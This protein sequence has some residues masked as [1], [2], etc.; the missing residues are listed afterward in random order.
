MGGIISFPP[1]V[2]IRDFDQNQT[3]QYQHMLPAFFSPYLTSTDLIICQKHWETITLDT[4]SGYQQNAS[5]KA[6]YDS[7]K[8]WLHTLLYHELMITST[9]STK[10]P[11]SRHTFIS[12]MKAIVVIALKQQKDNYES[13]DME[14]KLLTS[15]IQSLGYQ[16]FDIF[17]SFSYTFLNSLKVISGREWNSP[18]ETSWKNLLSSLLMICLPCFPVK[19]SHVSTSDGLDHSAMASTSSRLTVAGGAGGQFEKSF[20]HHERMYTSQHNSVLY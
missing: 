13:H 6:Y 5:I 12:L 19:E 14:M 9:L 16:D 3:Q 10:L 15:R 17:V 4:I 8:R 2:L 1:A 18:L 11:E 20:P 7:C